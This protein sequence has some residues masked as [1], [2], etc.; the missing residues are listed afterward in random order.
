MRR[1]RIP[2]TGLM[3]MPRI[4]M[5][6]GWSLM[7]PLSLAVALVCA[8]WLLTAPGARADAP[9][10]AWTITTSSFPTV[11]TAG[12]TYAG[13]GD[14][15]VL[16]ATNIGGAASSGPVT[17]TD[18]LPAGVTPDPTGA[19][20][21]DQYAPAFGNVPCSA[22][23]QVVTCTDPDAIQPGGW[24][25]ADVRVD[26][27]AG[28][29]GSVA[30][31]ASVNGG[32]AAGPVSTSASTQL[33]APTPPFGFQPGTAGIDGSITNADGSTDT[34]AGSHPY[35]LSINMAFPG[36]FNSTFAG[37]PNAFG[38]QA[39]GHVRDV[40]A[41]LPPGLVVNPNATTVRCTEDQL[42]SDLNG[43]GC[44]V[45]SQVGTV[46]LAP[47]LFGNAPGYGSYP[48][49]NMVPPNGVPAEFG[50]DALGLGFYEHLMG[51][52]QTGAGYGLTATASDIIA[53][54]PILGLNVTLW[55]NPS[56]PSHDNTRGECGHLI[57][58][59]GGTS[60]P[61]STTP[62]LTMPSACSG[63]L[64]FSVSADSWENPGSF[65]T[66]SFQT[67]DGQGQPVGVTG[68]DKLAFNPQITVQ[69]DTTVADSPSGL[70][71]DLQ[72]PQNG[73]VNTLATANLKEAVVTLPQGV[74]VNPA[75]ANGLGACTPA[76][77][78]INNANAPTCPDSS[79]VGSVEIDTP[80]LPDPLT[81]GI[82]VAQQDNNP[83]NSLLAIYVTAQAD[84]VW[85][86]LAGHVVADPLTGQLTTTFDNNPQLPF[87]DF[88]LSFFGG[89]DAVLATPASC[90]TF[91][92]GSMLSSWAGG[93]AA[94]SSDSFAINS[95]CGGGFAPSFMAS[96][97]NPQA[98]AFSPF[99]LSFSRPDGAQA[100]AGLSVQLPLGMLAKLAGVQECSDAQL[101]VAK[102]MSG[103]GEQANPSCPAG[104]QVGTVIT[105]SGAGPD[106]ISLT[107]TAYLTGPYKGA[108]Y[109]IAVVVPAVAGPYDL[110]TVVVRQA[111]DINPTTAQV[112]DVSD[113]LPTILQGIPLR[114]RSVEVDLNRPGFTIN[115][116]SCEP[117]SVTGTL[118]SAGGLT[119]NGN[120]H[121][122]VGGCQD[123]GFSPKLKIGLSGKGQTKS[124]DHPTLT[125]TLTDRSGQANIRSAKVTL[126]LA[127]AL[128]PNNS[129]H[130]CNYSVALAV[131]G[132]AV[133]C[134]ESTIVGT[135]TADTPLLSKPLTGKVYLVQGIRFGKNGQRIHTL[136]SLLVPLRGQI[137]LDLRARSSVNGA[138]ALVT[139]F[140]TIPDAPVSKFTLKIT[141]GKKGLLVITGRG[142]TICG[143]PQVASEN[144]GAQSGKRMVGNDTLT[145]PC[146][147][148]KAKA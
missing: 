74:S 43:G 84:G 138:G 99:V 46:A 78:G 80:L 9:A 59:S 36:T 147:R 133:G 11:F 120:S 17:I 53:K 83:F 31:Q 66:D 4:S 63:P 95:G 125:A 26:V 47:D 130:V 72:V 34:Q 136:P 68:C 104:S 119:Y 122:Q 29:A 50:F 86:K 139:T 111:L 7:R 41:E 121:F 108:P 33:N 56:D 92:S 20:A 87:T 82:Y 115:P 137:A 98:G 112:T 60:V 96:S 71:V 106:P 61:A 37:N 54:V 140:S 144:L 67:H 40:T 18:T 114:I 23:G 57:C 91:S 65:V 69:P 10:P 79:K 93:P 48:L 27:A 22:T 77:I 13:G 90:G 141:G 49:Y 145:T 89:S 129:N 128:D 32:G 24:I 2:D 44:P 1:L 28:A 42:E 38:L 132:G 35:Q 21:G 148:Q 134:P 97:Q 127:M 102:S 142:R 70:N 118:T 58:S 94:S 116:T 146:P 88:K 8:T 124:G 123:I 62:L 113:P 143:K 51:G 25:H 109:G 64:T 16:T 81:G 85:I 45:A 75:S 135:A 117:S 126:P 107:G 5:S 73:G 101:A 105:S 14:N 100:L 19:I 30:N 110:G 39:D 52:V 6:H 131:H 103:T 55:G 12:S 3:H 15:F 76:Q